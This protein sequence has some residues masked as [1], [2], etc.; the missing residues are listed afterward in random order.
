[1]APPAPRS[2]RH[3]HAALAARAPEAW[4][5]AVDLLIEVA[6]EP[7]ILTGCVEPGWDQHSR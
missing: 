6:G 2:P 4:R 5:L 7:A 1:M 3:A